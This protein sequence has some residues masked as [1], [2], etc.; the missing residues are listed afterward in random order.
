VTNSDAAS[1][2]ARAVGA[3][4]VAAD[5]VATINNRGAGNPFFITQLALALLEAGKLIVREGHCRPTDPLADTPTALPPTVQRAVVAR[6]DLIPSSVK[7]TVK[8]ASVL[9]AEFDRDT[10]EAMTRE[11]EGGP[12][13][14]GEHLTHI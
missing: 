5:V 13:A 10:L 14:V 12:A 7:F 4:T 1:I 8:A 9:G 11:H 2:I 6:F 3:S